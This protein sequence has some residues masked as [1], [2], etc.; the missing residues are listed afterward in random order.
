V[1]I[2]IGTFADLRVL[3]AYYKKR[4]HPQNK[5]QERID[6]M[7]ERMTRVKDSNWLFIFGPENS[8]LDER[9]WFAF[10]LGSHCQL[11]KL[12]DP[13]PFNPFIAFSAIE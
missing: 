6:V 13:N 8:A 5:L 10:T 3:V 7:A 2:T 12:P 1:S 11:Q 9:P 4:D